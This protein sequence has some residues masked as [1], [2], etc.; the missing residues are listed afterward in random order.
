MSMQETV[1]TQDQAE[2]AREVI[3]AMRQAVNEVPSYVEVNAM[4]AWL[5]NHPEG[6]QNA[7]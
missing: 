7:A 2:E 6:Q 1:L 4:K 3:E 5:E